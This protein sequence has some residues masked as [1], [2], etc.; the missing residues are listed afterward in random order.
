ITNNI[1]FGTVNGI[2]IYQPTLEKNENI[3]PSILIEDIKLFN[4]Q[5]DWTEYASI[6]IDGLPINL[7]LPYNKNF[8]SF[9]FSTIHFTNPNNITY[10]YK[11]QGLSDDWYTTNN[12]EIVFQGLEPNQYRLIVKSIT[13][14]GKESAPYE[15]SF[16]ISPPFYKTWWFY[17]ISILFLI[18]VIFLYVRLR[19]SKLQKDKLVLEETVKE[20]TKEVVKQKDII[21][22]KNKE[23]TDS[24]TY[25]QRIQ[26]AILPDEE[27]LTSYFNE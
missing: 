20:R 1:L 26:N 14:N 22:E 6:N 10:T 5:V 2:S 13:E 21:E 7:T 11:L 23:I 16:V 15:F 19:L 17:T 27:R 4:Q 8:V 9:Q 18:G 24:I 3:F 12:N 25:S